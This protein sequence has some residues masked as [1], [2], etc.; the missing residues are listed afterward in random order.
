MGFSF[1]QGQ[2]SNKD[3]QNSFTVCEYL[4]LICIVF[5][6]VCFYV[7]C[8]LRQRGFKKLYFLVSW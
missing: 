3:V 4:E 2:T 5:V 8:I 6:C 7:F 1:L